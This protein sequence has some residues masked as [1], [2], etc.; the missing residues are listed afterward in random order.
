MFDI[1]KNKYGKTVGSHF[2]R[3]ECV[4]TVDPIKLPGDRSGIQ[5]KFPAMNWV[6]RIKV[7]RFSVCVCV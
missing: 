4:I 6:N 2:E 1:L 7:L 3:N 5:C